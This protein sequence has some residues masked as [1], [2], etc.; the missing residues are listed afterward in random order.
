MSSPTPSVPVKPLTKT[1]T[2]LVLVAV[3][4]TVLAWASA[5]IVIRGVGTDF[6]PGSLTLLRL[7]VGAA[8]LAIGLVGRPWVKPSPREWLL[9]IGCGVQG[10]S[11]L[12][13]LHAAYPALQFLL[14]SRTAASCS[15][16]TSSATPAKSGASMPVKA[17]T[18][19]RM[20]TWPL[21]CLT[22]GL[23]TLALNALV[24][25]AGAALSRRIFGETVA[26]INRSFPHWFCDNFTRYNE[27]E[28]ELPVDQ[29]ELIALIAPPRSSTERNTFTSVAAKTSSTRN[30]ATGPVVK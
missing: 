7:G 14:C 4:V 17:S 18:A 6:T 12:E 28:A 27:N 16:V 20:L 1:L 15:S 23:F 3:A 24:F 22:L 5:F 30:P 10:R 21:S 29:H 2:P 11:H 19:G 9:I 26:R 25:A 13:A 8:I